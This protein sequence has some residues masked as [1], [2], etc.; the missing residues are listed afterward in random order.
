M[1]RA[2]D[3]GEGVG[4]LIERNTVGS[5]ERDVLQVSDPEQL[6]LHRR[7]GHDHRVV[8]VWAERRLA[9]AGQYADDS[10]RLVLDADGR[11]GWI[12][13]RTEELIAND[14]PKHRD[15]GRRHDVL[16]REER[17]ELQRPR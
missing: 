16:T 7:E 2:Q 6:L 13:A 17:S 9:L 3:R 4:H 11:A 12:G 10:E 5:R 15:F 14:G 1:P 8:L